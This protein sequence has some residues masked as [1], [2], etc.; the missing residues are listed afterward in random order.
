MNTHYEEYVKSGF[1][2]LKCAGYNPS[3]NKE[4]DPQKK[5]NRAKQPII[6]GYTDPNYKGLTIKECE[7]WESKDGWIGWLIPIG[8]IVLDIDKVGW[9]ER[10]ATVKQICRKRGLN[11]PIHKTNNG[12]HVFFETPLNIPGNTTYTKSGIR[13]TYREGGK[14]QLILAPVNGRTWGVP[15]YA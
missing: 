12:V 6:K 11:P 15:L 1:K 14:N 3:L 8:L 7:E 5:Y 9:E 2:A 13:V 10:F 4:S